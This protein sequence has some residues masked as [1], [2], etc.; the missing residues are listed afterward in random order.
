MEK[1]KERAKKEG[2]P[3]QTLIN[4]VLHKYVTKRLV[5]N[6]ELLKLTY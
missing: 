5:A 4:T 1:I 3:Y 2:M 6:E